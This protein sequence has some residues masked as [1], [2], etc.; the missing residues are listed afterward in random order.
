MRLI[1]GVGINDADYKISPII[2]GKRECCNFYSTWARMLYRCYSN[3]YHLFH[4]TYTNCTVA[5][6]W[7]TF[8]NFK[9]WMETQDWEGNCL[10]KDILIPGN[11]VYSP[12]TCVFVDQATN[13]LL[14]G[15]AASRGKYAQGVCFNKQLV[16]FKAQCRDVT[17]KNRYIG[18]F[19]TEGEA[20]QA[21]L[22]FK[23]TVIR[24]VADRQSDIRVKEALLKRIIH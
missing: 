8:S 18:N 16:K 19:D 13:N 23:A 3:K 15:R 6:E 17:G 10:D 12:D 24:E 14:L 22:K 9:A 21:Y 20:H 11:K 2:N 1:S 5:E 7:L 4:P